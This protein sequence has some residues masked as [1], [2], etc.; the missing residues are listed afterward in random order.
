MTKDKVIEILQDVPADVWTAVK[1]H[2][3]EGETN[4]K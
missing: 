4:G 2:I 3:K 1:W